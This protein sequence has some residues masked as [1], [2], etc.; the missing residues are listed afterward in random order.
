MQFQTILKI[1]SHYFQN[2]SG[3]LKKTKDLQIRSPQIGQNSAEVGL[4]L[5]EAAD[6]GLPPIAL[7]RRIHSLLAAPAQIIVAIF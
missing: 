1:I 2:Q 6:L 5:S 3:P 4:E 7:G